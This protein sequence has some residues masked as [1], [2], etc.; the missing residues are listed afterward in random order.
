MASDFIVIGGGTVGAA[1]GYG[2]ARRGRRVTIL[3]GTDTDLRAART[4]F[5]LV[6]VQGKGEGMPAYQ[7]LTRRSSDLWPAFA[8]ELQDATGI[9]I[10]Y[11]R[12]G[13]LVF[14]LSEAELA[15]EA[16]IARLMAAQ[17]GDAGDGEIIDRARLERLVPRIRFGGEVVGASF[18]RRDGHVNPLLLLRA[19]LRAFEGCGGIYR[20]NARVERI[21][22]AGGTF[23]IA[24]SAGMFEAERIV[25]A[26]GNGSPVLMRMLGLPG[27]VRPQRGQLLITEKVEPIFPFAALN[28]RQTGDGTFQLGG[29]QEEVG[30]DTGVTAGAAMAIAARAVR[31]MPALAA[32]R[33]VRQWAGL[34]VLSPDGFP[35]YDVSRHFPGASVILCHSGVTLAAAHADE[36]AGA[37][38]ADALTQTYRTFAGCRFDHTDAG[39]AAGA[40]AYERGH[41]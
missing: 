28:V 14:C 7:A 13:G 19:L 11:S 30:L 36:V 17:A 2:L 5:G 4:N 27:R 1:I 20:P 40:P 26:A 18:G 22:R 9:D 23:R 38:D 32:L 25:V 29:T 34:R 35:I 24:T 31:I 10:Q 39:A 15:E 33:V 8:A 16:R 41:P 6:W 21:E 3:D 37:L 12:P